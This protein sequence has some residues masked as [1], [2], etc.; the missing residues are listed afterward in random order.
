M[1]DACRDDIDKIDAEYPGKYLDS[2]VAW[3]GEL[4]SIVSKDS[5]KTVLAESVVTREVYRL[6]ENRWGKWREEVLKKLP[7]KF[8]EPYRLRKRIT[9][10]S[11]LVEKLIDDIPPNE[12][13]T[14]P[15]TEPAS[16][17]DILNA[18]WAYKI[19]QS[20]QLEWNTPE[21]H[22]KMY[23]LL[24]KAIESSYVHTFYNSHKH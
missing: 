12:I 9:A 18:G 24:L 5:D 21:N 2:F 10:L 14:W 23:R 8:K 17:Q 15:L 4:N 22:E 11:D 13:G 1:R 6:I 20:S 16:L 7:E 19:K 3:L